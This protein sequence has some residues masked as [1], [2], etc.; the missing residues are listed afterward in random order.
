[1]LE[2]DA[3]QILRFRTDTGGLEHHLVSLLALLR[4]SMSIAHIV[5][6]DLSLLVECARIEQPQIIKSNRQAKVVDDEDQISEHIGQLQGEKALFGLE[7]AE[8][9]HEEGLDGAIGEG[10]QMRGFGR[11]QGEV[12]GTLLVGK[13]RTVVQGGDLGGI[14]QVQ[15]LGALGGGLD[16]SP[17]RT[18]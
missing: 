11:R 10:L 16:P 5:E 12:V 8:L 15:A 2:Q 3:Q 7:V 18:P 9:E 14:K 6:N 1:M 4:M 17:P 13:V